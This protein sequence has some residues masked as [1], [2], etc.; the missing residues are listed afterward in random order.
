MS[1][2]ERFFSLNV[3]DELSIEDSKL[4]DTLELD[5][6][7]SFNTFISDLCEQNNLHS[8]ALL[9]SNTVRNT[10][11]SKSYNLFS[12]LILLE[13]KI[14]LGKLPT[15][16]YVPSKEVK[17]IV[18]QI[19]KDNDASI[20]VKKN[21][22]SLFIKVLKNI[23]VS[24]YFQL[25]YF[26]LSRILKMKV[27]PKKPIVFLDTFIFKDSFSNGGPFKDRYYTGYEGYLSENEKKSIWY[28]PTIIDIKNPLDLFKTWKGQKNSKANFLC[29]ESLLS[30]FDYLK[31]FII[32]TNL[33]KNVSIIPQ[34]KNYD[35]T[36]YLF[37]E[38]KKEICSPGLVKAINK[39]FYIRNLSKY[40]EISKV[41]NWHENQDIDRAINLSFKMH[42]PELKVYG[43]QGYV[44]PRSDLHK[45]PI[46]FEFDKATLPDVIGVLSNSDMLY[47]K[48]LCPKQAYE[49]APALRFSYLHEI[50]KSLSFQ[51]TKNIF[52]PLPADIND[53]KRLIK[54]SCKVIPEV[55][56]DYKFL[57]K[58]HPKY[59]LKDLMHFIPE[60]RNPSFSITKKSVGNCLNDSFIVF[61]SASS[62]CVE[63][64]SIGIP[65]GI[66]SNSFGLTM[67]PIWTEGK[68]YVSI[69]Y[70]TKDLK[71]LLEQDFSLNYPNTKPDKFFHRVDKEEVREIFTS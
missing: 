66:L 19:V 14:R 71:K 11:V 8:L 38:L 16:I 12:R 34:F 6:R 20:V 29:E 50:N 31:S 23:I 52:V 58:L 56:N 43:Y 5:I 1:I 15:K 17:R 49:I 4:L 44:S 55:S 47:K 37:L 68:G 39:Y 45:T 33:Y 35:V 51:D 59:T 63:A 57:I 28:S 7:D 21:E 24:I 30:L 70:S 69:I 62:A 2:N 61:S 26:I 36:S 54:F 64:F 40:T 60:L 22:K 32:S 18:I 3:Q 41:I 53:A 48:K 25:L 10:Y 27:I 9:L 67:N 13:K 46:A 42:F 65:V